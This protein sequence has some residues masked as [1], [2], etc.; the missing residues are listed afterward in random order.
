MAAKTKTGRKPLSKYELVRV[1]A[2]K[3]GLT[4]KQAEGFLT[5]LVELAID[6]ADVG[7]K[8]PNFCTVRKKERKAR[9]GRNPATG[10]AIQI[11]AKTVV[12]IKEL[13][14]FK[15]AVLEK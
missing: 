13:G 3:N 2:E 9:Q 11:P 1:L 12:K 5:S 8:I 14:S 6:Q 15:K 4:Q 7:L 10:E